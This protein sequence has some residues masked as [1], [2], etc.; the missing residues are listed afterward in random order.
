[1]SHADTAVLHKATD[2]SLTLLPIRLVNTCASLHVSRT[3]GG[4]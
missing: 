4:S 1:M 2:R 3:D